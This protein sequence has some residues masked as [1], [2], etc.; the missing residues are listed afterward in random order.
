[1]ARILVVDDD[2]AIRRFIARTLA[3]QDHAVTEAEDGPAALELLADTRFDLVI[4]DIIMP[5]MDGIELALVLAKRHPD[6]V[7]ILMSSY[8]PER[9]RAQDL[10]GIT[11]RVLAKPFAPAELFQTVAEALGDTIAARTE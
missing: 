1:M 6:L 8:G 10:E 3:T 9:Q 4:S 2:I 7:V 11:D 5:G